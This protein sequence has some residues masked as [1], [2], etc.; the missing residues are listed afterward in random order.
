MLASNPLPPLTEH[1]EHILDLVVRT[2]TEPFKPLYPTAATL[3]NIARALDLSL[4]QLLA[5]LAALAPHLDA[6]RDLS[7]LET[8]L[9]AAGAR[10]IAVDVLT[11]IA[12]DPETDPLERRRAASAILRATGA[13]RRERPSTSQRQAPEPDLDDLITRALGALELTDDADPD[14]LQ[15]APNAPVTAEPEGADELDELNDNHAGPTSAFHRA[16]SPTRPEHNP[17]HAQSPLVHA[18]SNPSDQCACPEMRTPRT[19]SLDIDLIKPG[20]R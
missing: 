2:W 15:A 9:H 20:F 10:R 14:S 6:I 1:Q 4:A 13:P 17:S 7:H 12:A 11:Q 16:T 19:D 3:P 5:E 8:T 18:E